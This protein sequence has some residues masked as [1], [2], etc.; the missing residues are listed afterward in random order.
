MNQTRTF[1]LLGLLLVAYLLWTAWQQQFHPALPAV[2]TQTGQTAASS[3]AAQPTVPSMPAAAAV[4]AGPAPTA[5]AVAAPL[6]TL[7]SARGTRIHVHTDLLDV[8]ID[9]AGGALLRAQLLHYAVQPQQPARVSLLDDRAG[10]YL[11][12]QSGLISTDAAPAADAPFSAGKTDYTLAPGQNRLAV[13]LTW[14]DAAH[15]I[16]VI[17]RYVFTRGSYVI[18]V[19]EIVHNSGTAPWTGNAWT[20]LLRTAPP[21]PQSHFGFLHDP[22]SFVFSGA[23]WYSPQD[24]FNK[25][26]L[27]AFAKHPLNRSVAGGW[28]AFVQH[29]FLAAWIPPTQVP[30]QFSS[31]EFQQQ[32]VPYYALRGV[33]PTFSV[34]PGA[35]ASQEQ[36]LYI[37]PKRP[38]LLQAAAPGLDLSVDYGI[39]TVIAQPLH[40]I[41][42]QLHRITFNWGLAIILLVLLIKGAF[43]WLSDK[44][45]RSMAK[46]RKLAPRLKALQERYADDKTK[47][48]QAVVELYQKEKVNPLSGCW[49]ML[50]QIPV[51]FALY[52]VLIESVELRQA[53]FVLWIHNLSAPDPYFVLPALNAGVMLLQQFLTPVAGMDPS[54][55]KIMKF[56]PLVMAVFFAVF[57]AGLVLYYLVNSLTGVMQQWWV[58]RQVQRADAAKT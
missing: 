18:R 15:G 14:R 21:I 51:F 10:H 13:D 30:Y 42:V 48:Q 53:P 25:L 31:A 36:R 57:P 6:P 17:K 29:Y 24:K 35:S 7:S 39:F 16:S 46:M 28:L 52:W 55:A 2:P 49:P 27:D 20:Q 41:L 47:M 40:W 34:A 44:Q 23:A 54:Q 50:V 32:G 4:E 38:S 43:F 5:T 12:A 8:T 56:M 11:V 19:R 3:V 45:Y 26:A 37:G 22:S 33:G 9:S 58:L 1:L